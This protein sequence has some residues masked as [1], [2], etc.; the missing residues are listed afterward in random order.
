MKLSHLLV[1]AIVCLF[2]GV[3]VVAAK[4]G[5]TYFPPIFFTAL[6]FLAVLVILLPWLKLRPV[7]GQ[8]G[9]LIPAVFFMGALHF[10][11]IFS[12]VKYSTASAMAIVNQLYVP[13][14]ALIALFWLDEAIPLRRATG[15]V[16]AFTGVI[17]FSLDGNLSDHWLGILL[18][19]LDGMAMA[20]GTVLLR[21]MSGISPFVMQAWMAALGFPLLLLA[22]MAIESGQ[23]EALRTAPWQGWA[24]LA[25]TVIGGN[26]IGHTGYYFLLQRYEVS[27]VTSTLLV[28]PLIGV[29][30]GVVLLGEPL[31]PLIAMG[32]LMTISGVAIVLMRVPPALF[33]QRG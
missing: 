21:R 11:L 2:W 16:I 17:V 12:G 27:L 18:L 22:S 24:A 19:V 9:V 20:V 30:S 33:A 1:A 15:I 8:W 7:Q 25:Y 29:L 10:A 31:T 14:A 32:G 4:T 26:L 6:R 3:N 28:A 13:F 23:T 5:V